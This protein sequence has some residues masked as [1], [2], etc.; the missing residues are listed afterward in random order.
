[1]LCFIFITIE[2]DFVG[3]GLHIKLNTVNYSLRK[4]F[5]ENILNIICSEIW[6][7]G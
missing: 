1:M 3:H 7:I 6:A 5:I 2:A 4:S